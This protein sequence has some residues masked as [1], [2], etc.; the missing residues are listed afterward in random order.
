MLEVLENTSEGVFVPLTVGGGIRGFVDAEGREYSALEVA[1]A[2]FR[3][4]QRCESF[5][6]S[7]HLVLWIGNVSCG[8][9]PT[10]DI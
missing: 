10:L 5:W 3:W 7:D 6:K 1:S 8:K 2:Y 9:A 4:R